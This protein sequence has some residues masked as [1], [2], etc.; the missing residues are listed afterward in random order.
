MTAIIG[1]VPDQAG[2]ALRVPFHRV[3]IDEDDIA[4]VTEAMR[5]GWL[6][7]GPETAAFELEFAERLGVEHA[8]ALNSGTAA[9]HLALEALGI[10]SGDE[11]VVPAYTFT[12]TAEVA[13]YL[14]A[15]PVLADVDAASLNLTAATL[16]P[17]LGPRT[18]AVMP[19]HIAGVGCVMRPIMDLARGHGLAVVED[20][21]HAPPTRCDAGAAGSIGDAAAFSFY[22]TKTLTTGEG[23]MLVTRRDD[24]AARARSMSLHGIDRV[25]Y[26]RYRAAGRWYYEVAD[27]GFKYNLTDIAAALGRSQLRRVDG[28]RDLRAAVAAR[29]DEAFSDQ[30]TLQVPHRS[31]GD[32][33]SWHLYLLRL[34]LDRLDCDRDRI[35]DELTERGVGTSVHF[36]PLHLHPAYRRRL[37]YRPGDFPVAEAEY[38]RLISLPIWPGMSGDDVDAVIGAVVDVV[39]CHAR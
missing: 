24:V 26:D 15:R 35:I 39:R 14:G 4:A 10:G 19:V 16:E 13:V 23:G 33:D 2:T 1:P 9:M 12:A 3:P 18:R 27:F 25:A 38:R 34:H 6:S 17:H 29:Y 20:A 5:S 7:T 28:H 21:A 22:A 37:G 31:G 30:E 36:I 32:A 8:V 11:V